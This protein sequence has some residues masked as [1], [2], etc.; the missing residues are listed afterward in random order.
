[1]IDNTLLLLPC[2]QQTI[3]YSIALIGLVIIII[4]FACFLLLGHKN[5]DHL[6]S[7]KICYDMVAMP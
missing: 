4:F 6:N 2:K 5:P 7:N 1:M 3:I